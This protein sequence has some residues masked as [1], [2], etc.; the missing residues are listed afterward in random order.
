MSC[1]GTW[2]RRDFSSKNGIAT[3][4]LVN[5]KNS[6]VLDT[7]TLSNYYDSCAKQKLTKT[8]AEFQAWL[9]T[10]QDTCQKKTYWVCSK[11][12]TIRYG[13]LSLGDLWNGMIYSTQSTSV[14]VTV[15]HMLE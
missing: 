4:L 8:D 13:N 2:H 12:G 10:H 6:M 5:G 15:S 3:V 9:I 11:Y 14:T 1:N 7:E